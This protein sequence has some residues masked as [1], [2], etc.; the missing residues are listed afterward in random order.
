MC[1]QTSLQQVQCLPT[2]FGV[3]L[4]SM[5]FREPCVINSNSANKF[6]EWIHEKTKIIQ[7]VNIQKYVKPKIIIQT[8]IQTSN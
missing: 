4:S 8:Q 3:S 7:S 2:T 5:K 1:I 6:T